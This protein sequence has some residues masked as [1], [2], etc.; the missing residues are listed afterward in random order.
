M[1]Y[2]G[3]RYYD[4]RM[5]L[6][7]SVDPLLTFDPH[8]EENYIEGEHNGGVFNN[9]NL[10][11]YSY[12]YQNPVILTD[13]NGKQVFFQE[14]INKLRRHIARGISKATEIVCIFAIKAA[15]TIAKANIE[16]RLNRVVEDGEAKKTSLALT[17]EFVMGLGPE[18]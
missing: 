4:P 10:N 13:P 5:S 9:Y 11:P 12:C 15:P 8:N 3:A 18:E 17:A 2:Y 7:M 14:Y 6:W 16:N 1:Y